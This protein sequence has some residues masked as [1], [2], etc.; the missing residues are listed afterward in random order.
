MYVCMSLLSDLQM[1]LVSLKPR[2][3]TGHCL[4]KPGLCLACCIETGN[5]TNMCSTNT[6][7]V[8][9]GAS[10]TSHWQETEAARPALFGTFAHPSPRHWRSHPECPPGNKTPFRQGD[11]GCHLCICVPAWWTP[12]GTA[13]RA[14]ATAALETT[15]SR[16]NSSASSATRST[17][18]L[19]RLGHC[20]EAGMLVHTRKVR[21]GSLSL[22]YKVA[23]VI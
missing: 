20:T 22:R 9:Y 5:R 1:P 4:M 23:L 19:A 8:A 12:S 2:G 18:G 11:R 17:S 3:H 10:R 21:S 15:R 13:S 7:S 14:K 6:D 16:S